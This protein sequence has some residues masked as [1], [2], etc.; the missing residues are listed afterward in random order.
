MDYAGESLFV[1]RK[2]YKLPLILGDEQTISILKQLVS[3]VRYLHGRKIVHADI[4][5][6]NI[7]YFEVS[8]W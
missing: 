2:N 5:L 1:L 3:A 6:E 4:K 8:H 7:L